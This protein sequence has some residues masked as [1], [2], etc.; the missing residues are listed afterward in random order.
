MK[1]YKFKTK[2]SNEGTIQVP[3]DSDLRNQ[4][5]EV[6]VISSKMERMPKMNAS[7]FVNKWAGFLS[8]EK[9]DQA[10]ENYLMNKYK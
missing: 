2:V 5:V 9:T 1:S 4:E 10:K 7:D 8:D 6:I 3:Q